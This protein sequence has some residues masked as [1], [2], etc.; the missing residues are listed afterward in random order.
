MAQGRVGDRRSTAGVTLIEMLVVV[1]IMGLFA[2]LVGP[3][4]ISK[5]DVAKR[6][7]ARAQ[8]RSFKVALGSYKMD[9]GEF[10]SNEQGLAALRARADRVNGWSGPYLPEEIPLDPWKRA[11][12]Y[13]YP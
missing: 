9:T 13:K 3:G 1:T 4:I 12:L 11:Y 2:A 7:A 6:T 5:V 8:V 10:P